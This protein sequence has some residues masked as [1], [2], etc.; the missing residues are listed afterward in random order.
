[1]TTTEPA[2]TTRP[3]NPP[4]P[5]GVDVPALAKTLDWAMEQH[6]K[7]Q[8][9]EISE[10]NQGTWISSTAALLETWAVRQ[11]ERERRAGT[12]CGTACCI[13]GKAAL[14]AGY[15]WSQVSDLLVAPDGTASY[16][17]SVGREVLGL[18]ERQAT[19][20]FSGGNTIHDLYH[21]A[22][23]ITNGQITAPLD[24]EPEVL[25]EYQAARRRDNEAFLMECGPE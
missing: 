2:K 18:T 5:P 12:V 25:T 3:G 8:R 22:G 1:M 6:R 11:F 23:L 24:L 16:V 13:A 14:D 20:L 9:G 17:E 7:A 15:R 19:T 4:K 10:W 21:F